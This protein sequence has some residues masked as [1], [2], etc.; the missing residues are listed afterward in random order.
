MA[1]WGNG[2]ETWLT[3]GIQK[4]LALALGM[5]IRAMRDG[6]AG[7]NP[8]PIPVHLVAHRAH[9]IDW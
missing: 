9:A 8:A 6:D 2:H 5:I 7:S 4:K 3:Q 1:D